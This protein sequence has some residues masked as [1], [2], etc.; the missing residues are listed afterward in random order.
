MV[1]LLFDDLPFGGGGGAAVSPE[2]VL[3][4]FPEHAKLLIF[5]S[6][7]RCEWV[8]ERTDQPHHKG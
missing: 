5:V 2:F 7:T 6:A 1:C 4:P 8:L 3:N